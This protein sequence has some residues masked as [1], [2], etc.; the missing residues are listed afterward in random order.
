M[1][2]N[3]NPL[4]DYQVATGQESSFNAYIARVFATMFFG[5]LATAVTSYFVLSTN[6]IFTLG[7]GLYVILLAEV[8]LVVWMSSRVQRFQYAT[9]LGLFY[10]YSILNGVT[11]S[12]IFYVYDIGFIGKA[13]ATTSV[14]FGVMAVYGAVTKNDL[15]R[16]GS[17]AIMGLVGGIVLFMVNWFLRSSSLDYLLSIVMLVI[18][19]GLVAYDTQKLKAYYY[20]TAGSA[21][22]QKKSA[23]M[24]ALSLYLDFINI[25]LYILRIFGRNRK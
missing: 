20:S 18:F 5:L 7:S 21:E 8:L 17:F 23:V 16:F 15:T 24:G 13:F 9:L 12:T 2:E 4:Q 25:F 19:I 10:V 14:T 1:Y 11:L 3:N 6:F 22:M